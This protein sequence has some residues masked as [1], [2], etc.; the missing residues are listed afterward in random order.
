MQNKRGASAKRLFLVSTDPGKKRGGNVNEDST[1]SRYTARVTGSNRA[2]CLRISL[3]TQRTL[4]RTD[5]LL[6]E[7]V[8]S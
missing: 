7:V 4:G 2:G 3:A 6:R 1:E 5:R 8:T